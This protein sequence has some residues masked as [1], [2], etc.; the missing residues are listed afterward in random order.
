MSFK[1]RIRHLEPIISSTKSLSTGLVG[2]YT[3]VYSS[4]TCWNKA[5]SSHA[6]SMLWRVVRPCLRELREDFSRVS[7]VFG[8]LDLAPLARAVS[9]F[10]FEGIVGISLI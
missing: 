10:N 1:R 3:D 8:P 4:T 6:S 7:A 9:D 5:G 2:W